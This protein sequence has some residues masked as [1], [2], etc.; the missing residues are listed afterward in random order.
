MRPARQFHSERQVPPRSPLWVLPAALAL[1]SPSSRSGSP[2]AQTPSGPQPPAPAA[3]AARQEIYGE[4]RR[5][6]WTDR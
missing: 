2:Q 3:P 1:I 5:I 6:P 4:K